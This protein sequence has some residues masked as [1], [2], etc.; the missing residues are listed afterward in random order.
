MP[1][2]N[3]SQFRKVVRRLLKKH[4]KSQL[5]KTLR[6]R[7]KSKSVSKKGKKKSR[8]LKRYRSKTNNNNVN[9][10]AIRDGSPQQFLKC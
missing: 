8:R 6:S 1:R 9:G 4:N 10:G 7:S 2:Q 3:L 5:A